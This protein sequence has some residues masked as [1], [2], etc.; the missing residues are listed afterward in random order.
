MLLHMVIKCL[1]FILYILDIKSKSLWRY[2]MFHFL[3]NSSGTHTHTHTHTKDGQINLHINTLPTRST[4]TTLLKHWNTINPMQHRHDWINF[5][6]HLSEWADDWASEPAAS[7][8]KHLTNNLNQDDMSC[9]SEPKYL[10]LPPPPP[11]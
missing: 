6:E 4:F 7:Q 2:K 8:P 9:W 3:W 11:L 5:T 10:P 1:H